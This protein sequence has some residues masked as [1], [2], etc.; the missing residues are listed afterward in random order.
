M[1][2]INDIEIEVKK[3]IIVINGTTFVDIDSAIGACVLELLNEVY[4]S[5]LILNSSKQ[6]ETLI[7]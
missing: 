5:R 6:E 3:D 7:H 2:Y 1:F 4:M